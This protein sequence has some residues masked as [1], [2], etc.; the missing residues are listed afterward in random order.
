[1]LSIQKASVMVCIFLDQGVA[2]SGG[3]WPCC[4]RCD[5]FEIGVSL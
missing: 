4:N 1:M 2:T 5:L 3:V